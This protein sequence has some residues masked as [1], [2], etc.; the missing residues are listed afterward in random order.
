[1]CCFPYMPL[2][3]SHTRKELGNCEYAAIICKD[4]VYTSVGPLSHD[5]VHR[6]LAVSHWT[7]YA[8]LSSH[9][10]GLPN[11]EAGWKYIWK[12]HKYP[13]RSL[14]IP[15]YI[16]EG[17]LYLI[18]FVLHWIQHTIYRGEPGS[19]MTALISSTTVDNNEIVCPIENAH[20]SPSEFKYG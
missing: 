3:C 18:H 9:S 4:L 11:A 8:L 14:T 5:W 7:T 19:F 2:Y 17:L 12:E 10:M 13:W 6:I 1:M 20:L 15:A 16:S